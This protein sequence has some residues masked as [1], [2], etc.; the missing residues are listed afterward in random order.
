MLEREN[1]GPAD[2]FVLGAT[3]R[4]EDHPSARH[5]CGHMARADEQRD[6]A[7]ADRPE[8]PARKT[9]TQAPR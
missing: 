6:E 2:R 4:R 9:C 1:A 5:P 3:A 7:N 8:A